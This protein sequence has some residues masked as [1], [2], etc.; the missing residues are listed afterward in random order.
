MISIP[1]GLFANIEIENLSERDR[2]RFFTT[3]QLRYETTADQMRAV[4]DGVRALLVHD[5]RVSPEALRVRFTGLGQSALSVDV[6]CYV[7]T[8]DVDEFFAIREDLLL[9]IMEVVTVSGAGFAFP[10]QTLYMAQDTAVGPP[11]MR[12]SMVPAS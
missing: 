3:L 9:R 5:P 2:I 7:L 11:P 1:N 12:S 8:A 4:L 6:Q 10:S